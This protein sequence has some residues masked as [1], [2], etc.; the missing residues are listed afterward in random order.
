MKSIKRPSFVK[1][2]L[3]QLIVLTNLTDLTALA[4]GEEGEGSPIGVDFG[5]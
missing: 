5:F 3:T 4:P 1:R 2:D